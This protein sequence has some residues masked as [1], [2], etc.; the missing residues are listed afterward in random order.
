MKLRC[1]DCNHIIARGEQPTSVC[2]GCGSIY[3]VPVK[4]DKD[5]IRKNRLRRQQD[6]KLWNR[7]R[8]YAYMV[9]M[10][11]SW[12]AYI[13]YQCLSAGPYCRGLGKLLAGVIQAMAKAF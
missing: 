3:L 9:L 6:E 2:P 12:F 10:L 1:R 4:L 5:S 11:A 13:Y 8:I 7:M